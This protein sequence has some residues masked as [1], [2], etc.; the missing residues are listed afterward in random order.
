M[1]KCKHKD[2]LLIYSPEENKYYKE[3]FKCKAKSKKH[4]EEEIARRFVINGY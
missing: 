3:C 2:W 1:K 4:E